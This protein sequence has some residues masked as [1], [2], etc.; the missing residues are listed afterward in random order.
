MA[1]V[2]NDRTQGMSRPA[3]IIAAIR[4][5]G[6]FLAHCLSN[7]S[8]IFCERGEPLHHGSVWHRTMKPDRQRLL[9]ALL[10]QTG[11]QVSVCK[12][13]YVQAFH[14]DIWPWLEKR[15]PMVIWLRRENAIRQAV[16]MLINK[17]ARHGKITQAQH[18]F[19]AGHPVRA[20]LAPDQV[21]R[22]ARGLQ[23]RDLWAIKRLAGWKTL[24]LTYAQVVGGE[25]TMASS[26]PDETCERVC[27]F[28]GVRMEA[29]GCDLQ[30]VNPYPLSKMLS[31][32]PAVRRAIKGSEFAEMLADEVRLGDG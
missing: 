30:R 25:G 29:L 15:R 23:E 1:N 24:E 16:S 19:T 17:R 21:L 18:S 9:A 7:H 10:D 28:L 27:T 13:V 3:V 12:L 26:M 6:T 8:Q 4:S 20:E 5:G 11:Y 14:R 31:N 2:E 22:A 32:W